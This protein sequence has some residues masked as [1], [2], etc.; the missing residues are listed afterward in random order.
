MTARG[1]IRRVC[2]VGAGHM[3]GQI[4]HQ[5]ALHGFDVLLC[6]RTE[7][8]LAAA[9]EE[10]AKLLRRRV[11]KGK[12]EPDRCEAALAR[13]STTTDLAAAVDGAHVIIESVVEDRAVKRD[14][15]CAIAEHANDDA[16]IGSNSSTL[17]SSMFA[18]SLPNAGRLLNVHFFNPALMMQLVEVVRGSHTEAAT[19]ER[20]VEFARAIGKTPIVVEKE[21]FGFLANRMLF[22]ALQEAY[23]LAEQGY[24]SIDDCDVAVRNALGWPMGPF[25]LSDLV[26]LDVVE[27]ILAEG[28]AQTGEARWEPPALLRGRVERGELGRK[29][30][31][32]FREY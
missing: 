22:I 1:E 16:I 10:S 7:A 23:H 4:A 12:L 25:E 21:S 6:S 28:R 14:V 32:G 17:P 29:T 30:K 11:E 31:K 18:G 26:G 20:A 27:A 2:V 9:R 24:V 8:R 5:A 13:V 15:L 3:G 19:L